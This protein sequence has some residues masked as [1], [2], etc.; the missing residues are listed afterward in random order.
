MS[1]QAFCSNSALLVGQ[2]PSVIA[3][4]AAVIFEEDQSSVNEAEI[5]FSLSQ[6][7]AK[8]LILILAVFHLLKALVGLNHGLTLS[9]RQTSEAVDR[10]TGELHQYADNVRKSRLGQGMAAR[11]SG[12]VRD[13]LHF[14][15]I[16]LHT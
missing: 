12:S 2:S 9:A 15:D 4:R 7:V 14:L 16:A 3:A 8:G 11:V 13:V 5:P 6:F 10:V 1:E